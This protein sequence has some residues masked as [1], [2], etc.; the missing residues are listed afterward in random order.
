MHHHSYTAEHKYAVHSVTSTFSECANGPFTHHPL[1]AKSIGIDDAYS[2]IIII[3]IVD[4]HSGESVFIVGYVTNQWARMVEMKV[5]RLP[6]T[7]T[8]PS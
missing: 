2:L 5:T 4:L 8:T 1:I 3:I 7:N 6:N